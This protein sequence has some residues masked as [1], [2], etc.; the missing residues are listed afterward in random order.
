[1]Q[2]VFVFGFERHAALRQEEVKNIT[3]CH[4]HRKNC[5]NIIGFLQKIDILL[6]IPRL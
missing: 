6:D 5:E 4:R 1:M 2:Y 3:E